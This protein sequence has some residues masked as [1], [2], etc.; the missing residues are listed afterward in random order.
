M[1][2]V[3]LAGFRR[4][5]VLAALILAALAFFLMAAHADAN[6]RCG[7]KGKTCISPPANTIAPH[8]NT[9][10]P[11]TT[12]TSGPSG[13]ISSG[14]ASFSFSSS[15]PSSTFECRLDGNSFGG[16]LSPKSYSGLTD[17]PHTF[18]VRA[19]DVAGN[20]DASPATWSFTVQAASTSKAVTRPVGSALLSD[21]EAAARVQAKPETRSGNATANAYW[22]SD[23]ELA[24]FR[25]AMNKDNPPLRYVTGRFTG[26]TDE[27]IQWVAHKWGIEE[28]V[29]RAQMV[30]ESWWNQN[31][32]GDRRDGVNASLYPSQSRIDSDSV[33]ESLGISQIKWRPTGSVNPGTEPLRWKSTAFNLDYY[34]ASVR[35]YYDGLCSWC[36]TGYSAGQFWPSVGAHFQP[37]PW[38][39]ASAQDY[40][41]KVQNNLANRTWAQPGF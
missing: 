14:S 23:A 32:M 11:D 27:I 34:G 3:P 7:H 36:G 4:Y 31:A 35:Y 25:A 39:N 8:T 37:L 28:D 41:T 38:G 21:A 17:G 19:K 24:E 6:H 13:T 29:V 20:V 1:T 22:P 26:T 33:Y 2:Q 40:I 10:A 9:I 12:I 30:Q 18:E 16:C 15:E 5:L